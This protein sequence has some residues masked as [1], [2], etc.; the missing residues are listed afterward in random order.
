ML[1]GCELHTRYQQIAM[2]DWFYPESEFFS[3]PVYS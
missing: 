3:S 1:L 2:L